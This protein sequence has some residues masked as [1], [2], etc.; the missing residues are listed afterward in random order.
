MARQR[1]FQRLAI[2]FLAAIGVISPQLCN[3]QE[4]KPNDRGFEKVYVAAIPD[5]TAAN[6]PE[7]GVRDLVRNEQIPQTV[8]G[9]FVLPK[10]VAPTTVLNMELLTQV[11]K[12]FKDEQTIPSVPLPESYE[13]RTG[14]AN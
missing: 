14:D 4:V 9:S 10:L 13:Q 5:D 8:N 11:P 2:G 12:N 7:G 3:A 1:R 6:P